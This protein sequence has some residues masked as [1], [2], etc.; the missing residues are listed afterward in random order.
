MTIKGTKVCINADDDEV[1][2]SYDVF[3]LFTEV[4]LD[5]TIDQI[6]HEIYIN[7]KLPQLS[8]KSIFRRLL[9]NVTKNTVFSLNDKLL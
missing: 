7:N 1:L 5:Q 4:L 6:I 3:S 9:C 2:V 8:S